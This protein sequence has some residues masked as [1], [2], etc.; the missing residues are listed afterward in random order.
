MNRLSPLGLAQTLLDVVLLSLSGF[1]AVLC[2][3]LLLEALAFL[4]NQSPRRH[5]RRDKWRLPIG[6]PDH[7]TAVVIIPAHNEALGIARTLAPL[8][9]LRYPIVVV[10]DNC[11]D[12]TTMVA[13]SLG[14]TVIE[15]HNLEARGKGYAM[16][17][18]IDYLRPNPPDVVVFIDADCLVSVAGVRRLVMNAIVTQR[19]VQAGYRMLLPP[20]PSTKDRVSAFAFAFKNLVRMEGLSRLGGAIVL[21]GSGMAFPWATLQAVDLA[22]GAIVEDMQLGID[23]AIA[24]TPALLCPEVLVTSVL[25]QQTQAAQTQRTRWE[26]GHLQSIGAYVPGLLGRS[27]WP[28]RGDLFLMAWDLCVPPLSL[29]VTVWVLALGLTGVAAGF[30]LL[31]MAMLAFCLVV[32]AGVM[33]T[34]AIGIGWNAVGRSDLPWHK[35]IKIPVYILSKLPLYGKFVAKPQQAW[36]RTERDPVESR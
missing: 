5:R 34:I 22:S 15:R 28:P 24:G 19:P 32:V 1:L 17:F 13:R 10:A 11:D 27:L 33:L 16:D 18:G 4:V 26:H 14:A 29:L 31:P 8:A 35:L 2:L 6:M 23:L 25:P 30:A 3:L 12:E 36:E 9:Q 7:V 20:E 21:A